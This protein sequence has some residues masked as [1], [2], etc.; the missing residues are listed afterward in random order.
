MFLLHVAMAVAVVRA[1]FICCRL[2]SWYDGN[3][4]LQVYGSSSY[5]HRFMFRNKRERLL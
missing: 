5:V 2:L 4:L 1:I 3:L